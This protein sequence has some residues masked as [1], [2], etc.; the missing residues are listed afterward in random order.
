MVLFLNFVLDRFIS[1]ISLSFAFFEALLQPLRRIILVPF[2]LV[3]LR[4]LCGEW[5]C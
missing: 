5:F 1:F 4:V 3:F 2:S